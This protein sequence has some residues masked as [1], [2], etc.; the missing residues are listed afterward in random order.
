MKHIWGAPRTSKAKA[1]ALWRYFPTDNLLRTLAGSA[2]YFSA[3]KQF[4]D[5]YEG[6]IRVVSSD[7]PG[8][9]VGTQASAFNAFFGNTRNHYKASCWHESSI[10]NALMWQAYASAGKGAAI[11]TTLDRVVDA[12]QP[13]RLGRGPLNDVLWCGRV[14]YI[15]LTKENV[16]SNAEPPVGM[17]KRFFFKHNAFEPER[18]FR[19]LADLHHYTGAVGDP[20]PPALGIL[21]TVDLTRLIEA[22]VIGPGLSQEDRAKLMKAAA[23]AGLSD[24]FRD[25]S[26]RHSPRF[27]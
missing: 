12:I 4:E 23:L 11:C 8:F 9:P 27:L 6:A 17:V 3:A 10:E 18:E 15:D 25:S 21:V 13:Y 5:Q 22:I 19:F 16:P 14:K 24:R 20:K 26:L 7:L 1:I 2:L